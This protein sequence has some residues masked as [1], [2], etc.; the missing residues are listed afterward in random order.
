MLDISPLLMVVTLVIF[1]FLLV[2]LNNKLYKP[3][4]EFMDS[5]DAT[6]ARDM[7]EASSVGGSSE[8][9]IAKANANIN[10][11]KATAAKIRNDAIEEGK[12][13]SLEA[14]SKKQS[15]LEK[16]YDEFMAK[17]AKEKEELKN[18]L[19]SHIPEIK[20]SLSSKF[21]QL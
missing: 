9:L 8:E 7:K 18:S 15:E 20:E 11:A 12:Q 21:A 4:L 5:R 19:A 6:I 10:N 17:L 16:S 2:W 3:L 14:I 13:K 1:L